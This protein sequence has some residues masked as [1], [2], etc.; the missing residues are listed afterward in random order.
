[1]LSAAARPRC[2]GS[3]IAVIR[4]T[5][6]STRLSAVK[7]ETNSPGVINREADISDAE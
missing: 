5:G 7:N 1:M 2:R 4:R 3:L 6:A